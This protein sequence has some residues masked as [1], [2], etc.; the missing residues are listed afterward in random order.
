MLYEHTRAVMLRL[1]DWHA[2]TGRPFAESLDNVAVFPAAPSAAAGI[3]SD[4]DRDRAGT[5][6]AQADARALLTGGHPTVA[7]PVT[8]EPAIITHPAGVPTNDHASLAAETAHDGPTVLASTV[9]LTTRRFA[10]D[11]ALV[12]GGKAS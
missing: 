10:V 5:Q 8:R 11:R 2:Q 9:P 7:M 3:G 6:H 1:L 12:C 4:G